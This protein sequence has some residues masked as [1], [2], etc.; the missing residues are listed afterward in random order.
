MADITLTYKGRNIL[1]LSASGNKTIKTA[2]KYCEA[3]I[4][5]AYVKSGGLNYQSKTVTPGASQQTVLPDSGYD[6][7]SQVVVNGDADL[8]PGNIKQGIDIFGV[9]GTYDGSMPEPALPDAYQRVE[10]LEFVPNIGIFVTIPTTGYILFFADCLSTKQKTG[11]EQASGVFGYRVG[12]TAAKDFLLGF[13]K[14]STKI[15]S[16]LRSSSEG[17]LFYELDNYTL[18]DRVTIAI[19]LKEPRDTAVIGRYLGPTVDSMTNNDSFEGRFFS[20][21][22]IDAITGDTVSWFVPCYR[23]ADNEIGVYD[24]IAQAFYSDRSIPYRSY[25][26]G[27]ITAGPDVN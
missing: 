4:G 22:G 3:D 23:K 21:K 26:L 25:T 9:V 19:L 1:E 18:G 16:Y 5:L 27:S 17:F 14:N 11:D 2:G 10:Y 24:L 13:N 6:A 7:L 20:L 8:I 15:D 12:S